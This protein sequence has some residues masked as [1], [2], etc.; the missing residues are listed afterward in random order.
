M[1]PGRQLTWVGENLVK[2]PCVVAM[3]ILMMMET[4]VMY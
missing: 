1:I 2:S 4:P 3:L